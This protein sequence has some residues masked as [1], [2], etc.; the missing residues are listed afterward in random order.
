M[1]RD[2]DTGAWLGTHSGQERAD[3]FPGVRLGLHYETTFQPV[4]AIKPFS[5]RFGGGGVDVQVEA[6]K[7]ISHLASGAH[8]DTIR[9]LL[10][11]IKHYG[12]A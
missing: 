5:S 10:K 7:A 3:S 6:I 11:K 9:D 2:A 4:L 8:A 1:Q 12:I